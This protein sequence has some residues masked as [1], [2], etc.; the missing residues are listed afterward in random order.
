MYTIGEIPRKWARREPNKECMVCTVFK[1]RFTWKEFNNR[2]NRLANGLISLGLK[3]GDKFAI[4]MINNHIFIE[5]YYAMAKIGV[6]SVPLNWRWHANEVKYALNHSDSIGIIIEPAFKRLLKKIKNDIPN[7]KT[8]ISIK[9]KYE[10]MIYYEDLLEEYSENE[11]DIEIDENDIFFLCYTGGTTGFPKAAMITNRSMINTCM[12]TLFTLIRDEPAFATISMKN[13]S[14]LFAL[15]AFHISIWPVFLLHF[16]GGKVVNTDKFTDMRFILETIQEE[17]ITHI[18][19]VPT[20]Y[21]FMLNIPHIEKF[22][23]SSLKILS[24]AGAPFPTNQLEQCITIFG[25]K[26]MQGLGATEGMPWTMMFTIDHDLSTNEGRKR[27]KS[28]GKET[29]LTEVKICDENGKEVPRGQVGELVVRSKSLMAGYWKDSEKTEQILK[30]SWYWTGD[31]GSMDEDGYIFLVDRK[32]DMIKS[33]GER[34]YPF[35]VENVLLKHPLIAEAI[36]IGAPDPKWGQ[37]I[38]AAVRLK[39]EFIKKYENRKDKLEEVLN[40]FCHEHLTAYKCPKTYE[41]WKRKLPKT[42]VG[43]PFRKEIKKQFE[44]EM[45]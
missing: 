21:H 31:I 22:N 4:L 26:F 37:R 33:G 17:K 6:I 36:V 39:D 38:H 2:I 8:Q 32:A 24:Y 14:T 12:D 27:I 19:L 25:S 20:L 9:E 44:K 30:N 11:P 16:A 7:V 5:C 41:F 13:F 15:P 18:N 42:M 34:I 23:L 43:K 35:E 29:L 1:K 3:K 28:C 40:N 45:I 10:D